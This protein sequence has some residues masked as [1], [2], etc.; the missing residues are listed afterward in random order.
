MKVVIFCGG[1][2][3]RMQQSSDGIPKPLVPLGDRPLL[4]HT[5]KYYAQ[6]GHRDFILCLG[7]GARQIKD[8]FVNYREWDSHDF[9]MFG[10]VRAMELQERDLDEWTIAFVDTGINSLLGERL[11]RVRKHLQGEDTF[12]CNYADCLTDCDL[13]LIVKQHV[14]TGATATILAARP[15][16]TMHVLELDDGSRVLGLSSLSDSGMM[17]NG[18]FMVLNQAIFDVIEPGEELIEEPFGRLIAQGKLSA[19]RHS[20]H[21]MP[22][23]TFKERQEAEELWEHDRAWWAPWRH[24]SQV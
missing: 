6:Y 16:R 12:L 22:I 8:Y 14:E 1:K 10:K 9:T 18:G 5:M 24:D 15:T 23:D 19:Y 7:Y 11:R 21:W 3:L 17:I 13:N 4:W 2:G 20:G